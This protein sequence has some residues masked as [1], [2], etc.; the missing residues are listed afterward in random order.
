[1]MR[2]S[3]FPWNSFFN[4]LY[5][6]IKYFEKKMNSSDIYDSSRKIPRTLQEIREVHQYRFLLI[7]LV[8]RDILTRYKRSFLG[9]AWTMLNPL[10]IMIVMTIVF[11]H[12]FGSTPGYPVFVLSGL[13]V[14]NFFSKSTSAAMNSMVWGGGLLKRIYLPRSSFSLSAIGTEIVNM[15]LS[16]V[17]LILVMLVTRFPFHISM[18]YLPV[19]I[20][21]IS[22]FS[23][24]MAL[25]LS[26]FS[27]VFPDVVEM[28]QIILTAWM[29]LT[30]IIYPVTTFPEKYRYLMV[31]NPLAYF[32]AL[33]HIPIYEGRTP[34]W[35]EFWPA[36]AIGLGML[37]VGWF[38]FSKKIDEFAYRA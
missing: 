23:L 14:W 8:R 35:M 21:M 18:L 19:S 12:L 9:V 15:I 25:L 22:L 5:Y 1:M 34:T 38:F 27:V 32:V 7:Q 2:I 3:G 26:T 28:Y 24:G 6:M 30:P 16:L 20:L 29:Y 10:G 11:S 33:F 17:P 4:T 37:F 31:Y 36:L 13:L